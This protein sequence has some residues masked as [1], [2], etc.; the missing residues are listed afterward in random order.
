MSQAV[1]SD[2][3]EIYHV[4]LM[5]T[6]ITTTDVS[7]GLMHWHLLLTRDEHAHVCRKL[8]IAVILLFENQMFKPQILNSVYSPATN[9]NVTSATLC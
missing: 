8:Q 1:V 5:I 2:L 9:S 3:N 4:A 6:A 7:L